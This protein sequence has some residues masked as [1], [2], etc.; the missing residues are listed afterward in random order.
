MRPALRCREPEPP[1]MERTQH[2]VHPD[3]HP[4]RGQRHRAGLP[5][6][7]APAAAAR[8]AAFPYAFPRDMR[9]LGGASTVDENARRLSLLRPR[10]LDVARPG[11]RGPWPSPGV[12]GR[13]PRSRPGANIFWHME[14]AAHPAPA[15]ELLAGAAHRPDRRAFR[16]RGHRPRDRGGVLSA[17]DV[18]GA[19]GLASTRCSAARS[20]PHSATTWR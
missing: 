1:A 6:E 8:R 20:R 4:R 19:N 5:R 11:A 9:K 13:K 2:P 7:R 17:Q 3:R 10:A 12:R 14:A 16:R 18:P 15:P